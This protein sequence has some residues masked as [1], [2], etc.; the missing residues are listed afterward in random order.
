M[1]V[2]PLEADNVS[3]YYDEVQRVVFIEYANQHTSDAVRQTRAWVKNSIEQIGILSVR[4]AVINFC[5]VVHFEEGLL[6]KSRE[7]QQLISQEGDICRPV[8]LVVNTRMQKQMAKLMLHYSDLK[9]RGFIAESLFDALSFI[10]QWHE[11]EA[12]PK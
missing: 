10:N 1:I 9:D 4:G 7:I 6:P 3:M 8:A 11:A 12:L 5:D 2:Q